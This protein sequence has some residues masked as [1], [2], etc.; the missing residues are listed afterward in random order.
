MFDNLKSF[1][2]G[3]GKIETDYLIRTKYKGKYK[4]G[5]ILRE[6]DIL[7]LKLGAIIW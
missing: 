5:E 4:T 6:L 3:N 1:F 7:P 2:D